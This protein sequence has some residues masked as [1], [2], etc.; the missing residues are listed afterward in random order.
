MRKLRKLLGCLTTLIATVLLIAVVITGA[1]AYSLFGKME[2]PENDI[3]IDQIGVNQNLPGEWMNILL[4]GQDTRDPEQR[5][6]TDTMLLAS[7]NKNTG[8]V[9]LTSIMRDL[10]VP[11]EGHKDNK[12]NA[13]HAFGGPELTLKTVNQVF[14]LNVSKYVLVDFYNFQYIIEALGGVNLEITQAE[15]E[16]INQMAASM[17]LKDKDPTLYDGELTDYGK[18][19]RL[20]GRQALA[21]TRIR[22]M[23]SDY[24]RTQRQR[25][26]LTAIAEKLSDSDAMT[27]YESVQRVLP[28]VSTNVDIW[29]TISLGGA[30]LRGGVRNMQQFRIPVDGTFVGETREGTWAMWADLPANRDALHDFIYE[31]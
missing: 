15:M 18:G 28:Y 19:T 17:A 2:R 30:A 26:V 27:L 16:T 9:K 22:K 7:V 10:F 11:I 29:D 6:R 21:Y 12:I 23:D 8:K 1:V 14:D 20:M 3:P 31:K 25:N 24:M 5:G 13:A 4:L